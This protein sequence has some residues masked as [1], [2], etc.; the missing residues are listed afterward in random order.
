MFNDINS[1][2]VPMYQDMVGISTYICYF[3]KYKN[4]GNV[5]QKFAFLHECAFV[6]D[7]RNRL[8]NRNFKRINLNG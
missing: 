6:S 1:L 5:N 4:I 8:L 2:D 3:C 7:V